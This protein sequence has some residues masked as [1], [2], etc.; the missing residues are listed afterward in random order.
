[1]ILVT[2]MSDQTQPRVHAIYSL[3]SSYL[4]PELLVLLSPLPLYSLDIVGSH[5]VSCTI[6]MDSQSL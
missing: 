1:M 6:R 5:L 4:S 3:Y 2:K